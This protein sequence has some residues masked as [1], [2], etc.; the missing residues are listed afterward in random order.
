MLYF[1][2]NNNVWEMGSGSDLDQF[3][4]IQIFCPSSG[5]RSWMDL[6]FYVLEP[7]LDGMVLL[8]DFQGHTKKD[9]KA[10]NQA[11]R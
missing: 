9:H 10:D 6:E 2:L 7:G 4:D 11:G 8:T 3:T 5:A 1:P